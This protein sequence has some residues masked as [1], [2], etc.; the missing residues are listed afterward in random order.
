MNHYK[1][2]SNQPEQHICH[3]CKKEFNKI[4]SDSI[5][6]HVY[7][8]IILNEMIR[9]LKSNNEELQLENDI[10]NKS[11]KFYRDL[12]FKSIQQIF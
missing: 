3:I 7:N 4:Y 8:T 10:L 12:S 11:L 6:M 5:H 1:Y 2:T 9:S